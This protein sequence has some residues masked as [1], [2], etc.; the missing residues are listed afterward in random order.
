MNSALVASHRGLMWFA[1]L[2][3]ALFVS[4]AVFFGSV[5]TGD[6][7]VT[8]IAFALGAIFVW[9]FAKLHAIAAE[10]AS[11]GQGRSLSISV[12][13]LMCLGFPL[14]VALGI[15]VIAA[16]LAST[17]QGRS[18]AISVGPLMCLG[19]LLWM[20]LGILMLRRAGKQWQGSISDDSIG[21]RHTE[22]TVKRQ[23]NMFRLDWQ[24]MGWG[25]RIGVSVAL[26]LLALGGLSMLAAIFRHETYNI[27][28]TYFLLGLIGFGLLTRLNS[29]FYGLGWTAM[30]LG[31]FIIDL[32]SP[33]QSGNF[34]P[35]IA[36]IIYWCARL[37]KWIG[38]GLA[39]REHGRSTA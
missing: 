25:R 26:L 11:I 21:G 20:I 28:G 13:R 9:M 15:L 23:G 30:L 17:A 3:A 7:I 27:I 12:G 1:Y 5:A 16:E 24:A 14:W 22:E 18:L 29:R 38:K 32:S 37:V 2:I 39:R 19:F 6:G 33:V 10:L 35:L 8:G 31:I 36:L 34:A 4:S